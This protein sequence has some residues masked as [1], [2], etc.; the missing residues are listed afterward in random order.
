MGKVPPETVQQI[1][2]ATDIVEL[3]GSY[4][5]LQRA[6]AN[7]K[8]VCP[9]H[10]EKSPSFN[11]NPQRQRF[12]CFGCQEGGDAIDF[13]KDYEGMSFVDA[14]QKLADRAGV[15]IVE[16]VYDAEADARRKSRGQ[17]IKLQKDAAEFFNGLLFKNQ[18]AQEARQYLT[19]RGI[20]QDVARRW[21]FGYAPE[22]QQLFFNWAQ[23]AGWTIPQLV[24]AGL[25]A[26]RARAT[27][28]S[29]DVAGMTA[30]R[31]PP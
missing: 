10:I 8:A 3:I 31:S 28:C 14:V 16:D 22:N 12:K 9:F 26:W 4:I 30:G 27:A 15:T 17:L 23:Q 24:D 1:L 29:N 5:P 2:D 21:M 13:V 7:Y 19:S 25:A 6:G 11:V 18:V 20:S